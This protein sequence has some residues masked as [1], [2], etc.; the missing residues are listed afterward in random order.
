MRYGG[1]VGGA[2]GRRLLIGC[3]SHVRVVLAGGFG[4]PYAG[5]EGP[6]RLGGGVLTPG[7]LRPLTF[8]L[9]QSGLGS[10][11]LDLQHLFFLF[12]FWFLRSD[13]LGKIN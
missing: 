2:K 8:D 4:E 6:G 1:R 10:Q 11:T 7:V 12:S 3:L 5:G 9:H 13:Y